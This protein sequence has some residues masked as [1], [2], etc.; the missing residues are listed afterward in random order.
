[1]PEQ[2]P[3]E[4][5]REGMNLK[6]IRLALGE[7][8]SAKIFQVQLLSYARG[9]GDYLGQPVNY[10]EGSMSGTTCTV[11]PFRWSIRASRGLDA[12]IDGQ[13]YA[14]EDLLPDYFYGFVLNPKENK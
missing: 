11:P 12:F 4:Q 5:L 2:I 10:G 6:E 7:H 3:G 14:I 9:D 1:V 13:A 8:A